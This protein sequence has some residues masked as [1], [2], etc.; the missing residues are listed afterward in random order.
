[1]IERFEDG[2]KYVFD[3]TEAEK[4]CRFPL[5]DNWKHDC[6]GKEVKVIDGLNGRVGIYDI[7]PWWCIEI[8]ERD[9]SS[10]AAPIRKLLTYAEQF[11]AEVQQSDESPDYTEGKLHG[12]DGM[13]AY[14]RGM[15]SVI[16][17]DPCT[18]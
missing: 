9:T 11:R 5:D 18:D 13:T 16:E 17:D 6:Q 2:K 15:L 10:K 12:I 1:M 14:I 8:T 7:N 3:I 4:N